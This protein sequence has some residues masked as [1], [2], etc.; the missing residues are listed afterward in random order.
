MKWELT[1][2][3]KGD[4]IRVK[5]DLNDYVC[6]Y[7]DVLV[8]SDGS[9]VYTNDPSGQGSVKTDAVTSSLFVCG[10]VNKKQGTVIKHNAFNCAAGAS[11][12]INNVGT[13]IP[14]WSEQTLY[15][16]NFSDSTIVVVDAKQNTVSIGSVDSIKDFENF[17]D[18][19]SIVIMRYRS[20]R[21]SDIVVYNK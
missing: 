21:L 4:I 1:E 7:R 9:L 11:R 13:E 20:N 12:T 17:G 16:A 15:A 14:D 3:K 2:P 8:N 18:G 6:S 5:L 10:Y 19:C